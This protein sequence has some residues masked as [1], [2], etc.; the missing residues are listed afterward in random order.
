MFKLNSVFTHPFEKEENAPPVSKPCL[1]V[2][3][4]NRKKAFRGL[5]TKKTFYS[6]RDKQKWDGGWV[7]KLAVKE[8]SQNDF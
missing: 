7:Q 3:S 2:I 4:G 5:K 1:L 6:K 8:L